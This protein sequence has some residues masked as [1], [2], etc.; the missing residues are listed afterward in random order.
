MIQKLI[1]YD[2]IEV[3]DGYFPDYD[4]RWTYKGQSGTIECKL[5]RFTKSTGNI[6]IEF[7]SRGKPSGI[8]TTKA[9]NYFYF[10]ADTNHVYIIPVAQIK[11]EI[12][13]QSYKR[14]HRVGDNMANRVYL[15]PEAVFQDFFHEY[16]V[17]GMPVGSAYR[18]LNDE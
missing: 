3:M 2:S 14:I 16:Q 4:V 18:L 8:Q 6:A 13:K 15:F 17:E 9:D 5:D 7:E 1:D 12:K 11:K 10:V